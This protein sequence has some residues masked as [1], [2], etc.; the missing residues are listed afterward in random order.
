MSILEALKARRTI[1]LF[2]QAS[3]S[4]DDLRDMLDAARQTSCACN[5]QLLRYVVVKSSDDVKNVFEQTAWAG[6]V[7]PRRTPV[8]GVSAPAA[9]IAV[10]GPKDANSMTYA[11]AGAAIQS[12]QIAAYEKGLGCCWLGAINREKLHGLLGLQEKQEVFFLLAVGVPAEQPV[13]EDISDPKD[14]KYY[15]DDNNQLH[16]PKLTVDAISK[17]L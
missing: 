16:V 8:W 12:M 14:V 11:D 4:S 7:K 6:L 13:S 1:R 5:G 10:V 2:K 3:V 15:L 17:W 9:F